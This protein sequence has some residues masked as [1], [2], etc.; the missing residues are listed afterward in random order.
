MTRVA[1]G[2]IARDNLSRIVRD[3]LAQDL[4]TLLLRET[5]AHESRS[6]WVED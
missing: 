3:K 2:G 5:V 4:L 1:L 6:H